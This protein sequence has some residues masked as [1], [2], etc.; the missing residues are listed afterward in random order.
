MGLREFLDSPG[1]FA[2][3]HNPHSGRP[4]PGHGGAHDAH[5]EEA[6]AGLG[7]GGGGAGGGVAV[8]GAPQD[9]GR[10]GAAERG[11]AQHRGAEGG[12]D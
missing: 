11:E 3:K 1:G 9:T 5:A 12:G 10:G 6:D 7:A 8:G 2:L 4:L